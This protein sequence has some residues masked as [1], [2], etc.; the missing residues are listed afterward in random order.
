MIKW[1]NW[2]WFWQTI[3]ALN[4]AQISHILSFSFPNVSVNMG[5]FYVKYTTYKFLNVRNV[6]GFKP[7]DILNFQGFFVR[8]KINRGKLDVDHRNGSD[9]GALYVLN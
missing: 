9:W 3:F 8:Q 4:F 5:R 6:W 7:I 2:A 1:W